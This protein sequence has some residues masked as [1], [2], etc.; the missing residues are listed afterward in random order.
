M[1]YHCNAVLIYVHILKFHCGLTMYQEDAWPFFKISIYTCTSSL[2]R[3]LQK[4]GK[5]LHKI[6]I[7]KLDERWTGKQGIRNYLQI[8]YIMNCVFQF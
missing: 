5:Q 6:I 2:F 8:L 4:P 7:R 1:F 3:V